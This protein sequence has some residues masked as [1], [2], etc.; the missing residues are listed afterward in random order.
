M[1]QVR[2]YLA[3]AFG[4]ERFDAISSALCRPP[5]KTCVRVNT[6][7]ADVEVSGV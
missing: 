6:L 4:E 3:A 7:K 5:L 1:R 2:A